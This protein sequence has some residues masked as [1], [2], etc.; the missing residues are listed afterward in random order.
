MFDSLIQEGMFDQFSNSYVLVVGKPLDVTYARFSNDRAPQYAIRTEIR[1]N[2]D[3]LEVRKIPLTKEAKA[4]V[5]KLS[6]TYTKLERAYEG[7]GLKMNRCHMDGEEAV[8]EYL[9]GKTLEELLDAR[10]DKNDL[11]GFMELFEKY[12]KYPLCK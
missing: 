8:F 3:G 1:E 11:P 7:S 9:D 6:E 2:G 4:H 10:M 12:C 5:Q